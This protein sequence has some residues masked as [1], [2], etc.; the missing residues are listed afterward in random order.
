MKTL[1]YYFRGGG[2]SAANLNLLLTSLA[3]TFPLDTIDVLSNGDSELLKVSSCEN[4]TAHR[5]DRDNLPEFNRLAM[6]SGGL[7]REAARL[8]SDVIWCVNLGAYRPGRVPQVTSVQNAFQCYPWRAVSR[9]R[10]GGMAS[11]AALRWFSRRTIRASSGI[12][13]QTWRMAYEL[14]R[15]TRETQPLRVIAKPFESESEVASQPLPERI[16]AALAAKGAAGSTTFLYVA[17]ARPH[18]N[19]AVL[20]E[21]F[22]RLK[23]Q[24]AAARLVVTISADELESI[25]GGGVR[26]LVSEG[27]LVALGWVDKAHLKALYQRI[28]ACVNPSL[29]ES[30]SSSHLEAMGWGKPQVAAELPYARDLC[31][32][33]ALYA[34]AH[35]PD[36][37]VRQTLALTRD[38]ALRD[39]LVATGSRRVA[40][41]PRTWSD[42]A[43][44][45]RAF[46]EEVAG[47]A[48]APG[49]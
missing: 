19:H 47:R 13:V 35:E 39:R 34:A 15:I 18:K 28:D 49:R 26:D 16:E 20:V 5:L 38:L 30:L 11:L 14:Q 23:A 9:Y 46:L 45:V 43:R 31:E 21:A 17:D 32:K 42:V 44:Q 41:F 48:S 29:L 37:W 25:C 10:S 2:G 12:I 24:G 8:G 36:A 40:N 1:F 27:T 6:G 22:R 4:L 3:T 7:Q 33:A